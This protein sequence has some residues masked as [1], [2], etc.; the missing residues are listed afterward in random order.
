MDQ[1]QHLKSLLERRSTLSDE[2]TK[3]NQEM[4]VKRELFIK[5]QGIIEYLN[6]IG[7]KLESEETPPK[8]P[9]ADPEVEG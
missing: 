1:T 4:T 5:V 6:E 2:I 8:A 7:V 3:L 9:E